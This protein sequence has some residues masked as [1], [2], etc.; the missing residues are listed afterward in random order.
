MPQSLTSLEVGLPTLH[1]WAPG[2]CPE[3]ASHTSQAH[4]WAGCG[5]RGPCRPRGGIGVGALARGGGW[6]Q[7]VEEAQV[8]QGPGSALLLPSLI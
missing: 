1:H 3:P 4:S 6:G 2:I 7:G 8:P 5:S